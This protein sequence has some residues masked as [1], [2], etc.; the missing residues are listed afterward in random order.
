MISDRTFQHRIG[1]REDEVP[2]LG[3]DSDVLTSFDRVRPGLYLGRAE[4]SCF[5]PVEHPDY[6]GCLE[7][8]EL[9]VAVPRQFPY[10]LHRIPDGTTKLHKVGETTPSLYFIHHPNFT[11]VC[12]MTP[13]GVIV[14]FRY[15]TV[16]PVD[17]TTFR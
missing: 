9:A 5:E 3:V 4:L 2:R 10:R 12:A 15:F 1:G 8:Y 11:F 16:C 17:S 13:S 14:V 7:S 6:I